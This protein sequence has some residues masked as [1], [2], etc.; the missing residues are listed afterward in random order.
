MHAFLKAGALAMASAGMALSA[1]VTAAPVTHSGYASD[2][3]APGTQEADY[4]PGYGHRHYRYSR[5]DRRRGYGRDDY[6]ADYRRYDRPTRVWR[7]RNGRYYCRKQDG[8]TGLLIGGAAGALLGNSIDGGRDRTVGT[9]LGALGGA[10]LGREID[11]S[12][13]RCR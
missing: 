8:T 3:R 11:R 12:G 5:D 10:L 7:G 9:L 1:P 2:F 13:S 4:G 6:R